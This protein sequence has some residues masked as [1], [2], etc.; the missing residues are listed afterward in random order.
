LAP[1]GVGDGEGGV[2][3]ADGRR[4]DVVLDSVGVRV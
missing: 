4:V 1:L 2:D 3:E